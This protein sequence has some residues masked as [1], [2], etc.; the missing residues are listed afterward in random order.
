MRMSELCLRC[1]HRHPADTAALD[2]L[3]TRGASPSTQ[4]AINKLRGQLEADLRIEDLAF[5]RTGGSRLNRRPIRRDWCRAQSQERDG[6]YYF[7]EWLRMPECE[8]LQ[9]EKPISGCA[10]C[11]TGTG[12][13]LSM[14][15]QAR[16]NSLGAWTKAPPM[17]SATNATARLPIPTAVPSVSVGKDWELPLGAAFDL[18]PVQ[19][20]ME[21][22]LGSGSF[23][24][25]YELVQMSTQPAIRGRG[26]AQ[27][28]LI[29]GG[30]G[31]GKTHYFKYLLS[32]LLAH[33][34]RPGCLLLDPK[35]VLTG[36]LEK[37]LTAINRSRDLIALKEGATEH[38]FNVLGDDLPAKELGRLLSEVVLAGAMGIDE[39]WA[40]LVGDLLEAGA[41]VI[42]ADRGYLTASDLLGDI[43]YRKPYKYK[44]G[45]QI[46]QYPIVM[47]AAK[48]AKT[49]KDPDVR[50]ACDRISEYFTTVEDKTKRFV[51]Q[52]IERSLAELRSPQWSYLSQRDTKRSVYTDIIRRGC[53]VTVA[54]GQGSPAFQRSLSTL[55]K[56]LFQQA[57][58]ADLARRREGEAAPFF[59]LACDEYA[60]AITEGE[61][62]LVS[63]SRFF[64]LSR[65]AGCM[66]LLALQSLATGRSRFPAAMHDRWAAVLGNV[67]V[68]FF[69]RVNDVDTAEMGS[70]LAGSQ[71]SF[72]PVLSQQR[73][74]QGLSATEAVTM[75]EHPCV[76]AWY[77]TNRMPQ[78]FALVHGTL[79]GTS[80]PTSLFVKAPAG[81]YA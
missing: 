50:I 28:S 42:A 78:G 33:P 4:A 51:R 30:P 1:R 67:T 80:I 44:D 57:V 61:T 69:M 2:Q 25:D 71:H 39:G 65:E 68:K 40:V 81:D 6:L 17:G 63:D 22:S 19:R 47:R 45:R 27:T 12:V 3:V 8:F 34:Q 5:E 49:S 54:V 52:V 48:V 76:P 37:R 36:W 60:Q 43:L 24:V 72:V 53:I 79:D 59:I 73:S 62:G 14:G 38:A 35:G 16:P 70:A 41:Q 66:S 21:A 55:V 64:S 31:A 75:L 46:D 77:L 10:R 56:S 32:N 13:C 9:C 58:L 11:E 7:C 74:V 20:Q 23:K 18:R 26:L 15:A 29:F